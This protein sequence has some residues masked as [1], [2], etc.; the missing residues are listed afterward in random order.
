MARAAN[1]TVQAL[2]TMAKKLELNLTDKKQMVKKME[3]E[4]EPFV[5]YMGYGIGFGAK[6]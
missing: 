2:R 1:N 4:I 5:L 6:M 3:Q